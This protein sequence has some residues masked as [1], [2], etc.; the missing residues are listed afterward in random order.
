MEKTKKILREMTER[1]ERKNSFRGSP[2]PSR[3]LNVAPDDPNA[4][5]DEQDEDE[6]N[7]DEQGEEEQDEDE[8][9]EDEEEQWAEDKRRHPTL[10]HPSFDDASGF[11]SFVSFPLHRR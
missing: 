9:E 4:R 6:D 3:P 1:G 8:Q 11:G 7:D 5:E 2:T 10:F